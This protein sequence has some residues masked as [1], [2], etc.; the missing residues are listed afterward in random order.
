MS[1][2][3]FDAARRRRLRPFLVA[4]LIVLPACGGG[5]TDSSSASPDEIQR[6]ALE[7]VWARGSDRARRVLCDEFRKN[8]ASFSKDF[9]KVGEDRVVREFFEDHCDDR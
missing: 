1:R 4:W 5:Q 6:E 9:S 7:K 8:P 2:L 3:H